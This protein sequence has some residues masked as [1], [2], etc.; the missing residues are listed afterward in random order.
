MAN[1]EAINIYWNKVIKIKSNILDIKYEELVDDPGYY[2][3]KIYDFLEIES[4][5]DEEKRKAF[6]SHTA[7]MRQI[8]TGVHKKSVGKE[9]FVTHKK[10][11]Y[12]SLSMQ[13]KYWQ[14][15]GLYSNNGD[16]FGYKISE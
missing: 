4:E 8:G 11:F 5:F 16:F 2:Q 13:R 15:I 14:K 9:E 6:F 3:K 10:E 12:E 1:F 7:S